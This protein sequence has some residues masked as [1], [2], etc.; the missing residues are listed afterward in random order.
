[1]IQLQDDSGAACRAARKDH[2]L[3]CGHLL[4]RQQVLNHLQ[5]RRTSGQIHAISVPSLSWQKTVL[6]MSRKKNK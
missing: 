5:K 1:M 2:L 3:S 4:P 6:M